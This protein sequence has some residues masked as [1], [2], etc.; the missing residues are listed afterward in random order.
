MK[1][2]SE[3]EKNIENYL[4]DANLFH[5]INVYDDSLSEMARIGIIPKTKLEI[6]IEGGEGY[7]PHMHICKKSGKNIVLRLKLTTN[8][9]FREKDDVK[10]VLSAAERKAL[11]KYLNQKVP[12]SEDTMWV[13]IVNRWNIFNSSHMINPH[14]IQQ[15]DYTEINEPN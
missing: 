10:N 14:I 5:I 7:I 4:N 3:I 13:D 9:Y 11:N 12:F 2:I 8:E 6:H 1:K 15:P